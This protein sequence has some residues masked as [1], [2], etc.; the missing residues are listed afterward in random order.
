MLCR[1]AP[2]PV[3]CGRRG[4]KNFASGRAVPCTCVFPTITMSDVQSHASVS[5]PRWPRPHLCS[6]STA[7]RSFITAWRWATRRNPERPRSLKS[8]RSFGR[9]LNAGRNFHGSTNKS[10][11]CDGSTKHCGTVR[12]S[13]YATKESRAVSYVRKTKD[14]EVLVV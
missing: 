2:P 3:T 13:G 9:L 11:H 5:R 8:Y 6:H 12:W 1:D 14:E 4:R 7:F 10:L